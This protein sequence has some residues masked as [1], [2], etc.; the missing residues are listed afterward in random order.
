MKKFPVPMKQA[1]VS[2]I[3]VK[4]CNSLLRILRV[5]IHSY[6]KSVLRYKFLILDTSSGHYIYMSKD[7]RIH[8]Y[9][10]KPKMAREQ[11]CLGNTALICTINNYTFISHQQKPYSETYE[12]SI[13]CGS[14]N[15][16]CTL[17][18]NRLHKKLYD[19]SR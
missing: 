14:T 10:S 18:S 8:G 13:T 12:G 5:C 15:N 3:K 6:L 19:N 7:M 1:T 17:L 9:F 16:G 11:Q 4:S 2:L